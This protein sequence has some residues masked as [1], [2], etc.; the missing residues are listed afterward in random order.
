MEDSLGYSLGYRTSALFLSM[1]CLLQVM[2]T[3][4]YVGK[5]CIANWIE[6]WLH[7]LLPISVFKCEPLC[8]LVVSKGFINRGHIKKITTEVI[9]GY[10][11]ACI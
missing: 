5:S 2:C 9:T 1:L 3:K 8:E 7:C 11:I 4:M 6:C 10:R